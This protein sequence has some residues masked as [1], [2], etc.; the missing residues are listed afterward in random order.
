MGVDDHRVSFSQI[1]SLVG[2]QNIITHFLDLDSYCWGSRLSGN[3][4]GDKVHICK[5]WNS[6]DSE[7]YWCLLAYHHSPRAW[8]QKLTKRINWISSIPLYKYIPSDMHSDRHT[9]YGLKESQG[10]HNNTLDNPVLAIFPIGQL[11]SNQLQIT[12]QPANYTYR[13]N[14]HRLQTWPGR[15]RL[16]PIT[17][18]Q[19]DVM[20]GAQSSIYVLRLVY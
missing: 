18:K 11:L 10:Q 7:P 16:A 8:Y 17:P 1:R 14:Q 5:I 12:E 2:G 4:A 3:M 13:K 9:L 6:F 20:W 19:H 15:C